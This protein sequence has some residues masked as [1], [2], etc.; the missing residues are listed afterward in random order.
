[1]GMDTFHNTPKRPPSSKGNFGRAHM[2]LWLKTLYAQCLNLQSCC[3]YGKHYSI[4]FNVRIPGINAF[5]NL[6]EKYILP[7]TVS[8]SQMNLR[9]YKFK[10]EKH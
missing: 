7:V 6:Y 4:L 9:I 1:M 10:C 3:L 8:V 5:L 2:E